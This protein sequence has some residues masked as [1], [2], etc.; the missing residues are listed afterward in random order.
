MNTEALITHCRGF[1]ENQR[2]TCVETIYQTDRVI[3]SAYVFIQ[4]VCEIVGYA[5][6]EDDEE[7]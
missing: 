2:I 1:I 4:G 3:E 6:S 5:K 7:D